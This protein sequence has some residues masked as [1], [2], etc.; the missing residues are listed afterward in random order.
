MTS[1]T[2]SEFRPP[3]PHLW[4]WH[5]AENRGGL[6][7]RHKVTLSERNARPSRWALKTSPPP[8]SRNNSR[9][10]GR[11]RGD[12]DRGPKGRTRIEQGSNMPRKHREQHQYNEPDLAAQYSRIGIDAVAAC[13]RYQPGRQE[14]S[15]GRDQPTQAEPRPRSRGRLRAAAKTAK[16]RAG[17]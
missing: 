2:A 12:P 10:H 1:L 8:G 7:H 15:A 17:E 6:T 13:A 11:L 16:G 4:N 3:Q 9:G 14:V 5:P